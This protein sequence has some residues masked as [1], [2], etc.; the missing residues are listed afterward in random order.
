MKF[1]PAIDRLALMQSLRRLYGFPVQS[2]TFVPEGF[3]GQHYVAGCED[4][5]RY[6]VTLLNDSRLARISRSNLDFT[7]PLLR[8]LYDGNFFRALA[9]PLPSLAGDLQADF[10]GGALVVYVHIE[11]RTLADGYPYTPEMLARLGKLVARLH[12]S[13]PRIG[14]EIPHVERFCMP[15]ED[16]LLA[17]LSDLEKVTTGQS[18]G[19]VALRDLLLPRRVAIL[20]L[21][22]CLHELAGS[23]L[24]LHPPMVL[25]HT[26]ITPAN[27]IRTPLDEL[28][29]VDWEETLLAPA[30]ADLF[31]FTGKDFPVF[32][33]EYV[34]EAGV[35]RLNVELFSFYMLRRN[36]VDLTDWIVTILH[37]NTAEEQDQSDVTGILQDCTLEWSDF[38]RAI[39]LVREQLKA[40]I[41]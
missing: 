40:V 15:F 14:M 41:A 37:E 12:A 24:A 21:L 8:H 25:C 36:L 34:R 20:G 11:G 39:D 22:S 30:E 38:E 19:Q 17:G 35:P 23:A 29:L 7:L 9:A 28:V 1:E 18:R 10:Q 27:I 2:L 5:K 6:F 3:V 32:L 31:I 13:T 4:G 16:D 26:D 33:E